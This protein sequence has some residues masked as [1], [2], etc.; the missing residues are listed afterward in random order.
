MVGGYDTGIQTNV[1]AQ[2]N[3]QGTAALVT[4]ASSTTIIGCGAQGTINAKTNSTTIF[5]I[6]IMN[7][8]LRQIKLHVLNGFTGG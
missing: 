1:A 6:G 2:V 4:M 8:S 7:R 5:T 3:D